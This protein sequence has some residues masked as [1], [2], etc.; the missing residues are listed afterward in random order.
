MVQSNFF[1]L[2]DGQEIQQSASLMRD[3]G[4]WQPRFTFWNSLTS[5]FDALKA[6]LQNNFVKLKHSPDVGVVT[7]AV[8]D[9][10]NSPTL[11]LAK[12]ALL[13]LFVVLSNQKDPVSSRA[14]RS[15]PAD[16][17]PLPACN[18]LL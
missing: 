1:T 16:F 6:A 15:R 9:G 10:M 17:W 13:N 7:S 5:A 8:Y 11:C 18:G 3:P 12:M 14:R 2:T 4:R